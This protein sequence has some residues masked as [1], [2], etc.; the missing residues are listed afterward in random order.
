M[1]P[2]IQML[3]DPKADMTK[4]LVEIRSLKTQFF[5]DDGVVTAVDGVDLDV[6]PNRTMVVLGQSGSGKSIMARSILRIVDQ[7][8]K[9][10]EGS[11]LYNHA[12]GRTIDLAKL[13]AGSPEVRE[14]RGKD[15][16][17]IFQEPMSSLGPIT[18]IGKQIVETILLHRNVTKIEAK[19]IAIDLLDRVGIP[20]PA[21]RFEAY[22]FELS[23]G[24]RQRAMIAMALSCEPRLLIADEPSTALDVTT[25]AQILDLIAELKEERQM[26]VMLITHDMGVAAEVAEDIVVMYHG[27][28]IEKND[29]YSIFDAPKHPYT[30]ALLASVPKL[31]G[32]RVHRLPDIHELLKNPD[33]PP[34]PIPAKP[35]PPAGEPIVKVRNVSVEFPVGG[36]VFSKPTG[37]IQAV[38]NVSFDVYRGETFGIVGESGS[39]KSTL[40]RAI[41][42]I[43]PPTSGSIEFLRQDKPPTE[44][45]TADK[46]QM[47]DVWRD[48]RMVF[49]DP[50]SSLNPRLRVIDLI[51]QCIEKAEGIGRKELSERVAKLLKQV[52]LSPEYLLRHPN[53]FS[54]GQRQRLGVARALATR[55]ELVIADEAVSALDVPIQAQVLNLLQDLQEEFKLTYIFISHDLAVVDHI[56]DRVAVMYKGEMVELLTREELAAGPKHPYTKSLLSAVPIPDP[57]LRDRKK[58]V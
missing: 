36:G 32:Q 19:E 58:V 33:N 34:A 8:G 42:G 30:R 35:R 56:C 26:G 55:P 25:Q 27:K 28:I 53:A 44:I 9:I 54:G 4:P 43:R 18:K 40:S 29:V 47:R 2:Q 6:M 13:R 37:V 20:R 17:M 31:G 39:G 10:T 16:S 14:I 15:I 41:M 3:I 5:T 7:P 12:D 11:I 45:S 38:N 1:T 22:P 50:Q 24:M 21:E 49:Q 51:G 57:H 46:H 23:G 52:G 48:M